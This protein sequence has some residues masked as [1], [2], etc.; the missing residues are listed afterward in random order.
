MA[1][2]LA[3]LCSRFCFYA[4]FRQIRKQRQ[5]FLQPGTPESSPL[6][7]KGRVSEPVRCQSSLSGLLRFIGIRFAFRFR[8][9]FIR[10]FSSAP[11][12]R[13][14]CSRQIRIVNFCQDATDCSRMFRCNLFD[15]Q[16]LSREKVVDQ[17]I[18]SS[19]L[20]NVF[21]MKGARTSGRNHSIQPVCNL[22]GCRKMIQCS[23]PRSN[24][25]IER[26]NC[27]TSCIGIYFKHFMQI[28]AGQSP[29]FLR[30]SAESQRAAQLFQRIS[31]RLRLCLCRLL[32]LLPAFGG[33]V[34]E[35]CDFRS[36]LHG[37]QRYPVLLKLVCRV[38]QA[39][40]LP[41]FRIEIIRRIEEMKQLPAAELCRC[42][43]RRAFHINTDAALCFPAR[44]LFFCF[45]VNGICRPGLTNRITASETLQNAGKQLS[46]FWIHRN[47]VRSRHVMIACAF[48]ADC[49]VRYNNRAV[50]DRRVQHA[51]CAEQDNG[52]CAHGP[53]ILKQSHAGR[54]PDIAQEN[55][56]LNTL[57]DHPV[58][59]DHHIC[60]AAFR[61]QFPAAKP[62]KHPCKGSPRKAAHRHLRHFLHRLYEI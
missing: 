33:T 62:V 39:S 44:S 7:C 61:Q 2:Y 30:Q 15:G 13:K 21:S 8:H 57:P 37:K 10:R 9:S 3:A 11:F 46:V 23:V 29:R 31:F 25:R 26:L 43:C 19:Q 6:R 45:T 4:F 36:Q 14:N 49:T 53:Y 27:K 20:L 17:I 60:C 24:F 42:R 1:H 12:G 16:G 41:V 51:A 18:L 22:L 28:S 48:V 47:L 52:L 35:L 5:H 32:Y 50:P 56:G 34:A 40:G 38:R 58:N 55:G 59:R 54:R